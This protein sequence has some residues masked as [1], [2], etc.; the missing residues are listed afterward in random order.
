MIVQDRRVVVTGKVPNESRQTAERKLREA[1]AIVQSAVGKDTDVLVT[2]SAVGAK[3]LNAAKAQ[4]ILIVPWEEA[5]GN[6]SG[7]KP[8]PAP[9]APMPAVK[10]WAP[11]LCKGA[12]ELPKGD[13]W[14]FEIKWDGLRGIATI[15]G[16][17]VSLQSRSGKSDLTERFPGIVEE[18]SGLQDCVL[19]GELAVQNAEDGVTRFIAFDVLECSLANVIAEPLA[20]RRTILE[21]I[22]G[23]AGIY[24]AA[25]P[26]FEDGRELLDYVTDAGLEGIVAK[27]RESR[28]IEG[29]RND[30]WLKI[31]VR[32][33]QEFIVLG[34]T[35]GEGARE[36]AFGALILGY[37]DGDKRIYAGKVG[38]GFDDDCLRMLKA[39]M[40]P[41]VGDVENLAE[42]V[43]LPRDLD[44]HSVYLTEPGI[45]VQV[46][47]Q[48]WTEDG[49][50]WHP[51][52]LRVR[53]DKEATDVTREA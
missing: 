3:K 2:G 22:V 26:V 44:T 46:A 14:L 17:Q 15:K 39:K 47:F 40:D 49:R 18:L 1:G 30:T 48:K 13:G 38:T 6:A 32:R 42:G 37:Y 36:W 19:D 7:S 24:I 51:S 53:E 33:E 27:Q 52:Y 28:Y 8:P 10:Q 34:Y 25:S 5:F 41:L 29:A 9:R 21:E 35:P 12:T 4:G 31:K 23:R 43:L 11:M 20:L 16:G 50:L 45:V